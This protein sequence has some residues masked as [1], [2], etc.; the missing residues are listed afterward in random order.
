CFEDVI[1]ACALYRPGPLGSGM[2]DDFIDR[3]H[4]KK[5]VVYDLPELEPILKDTYGVIVYQE[6][7]MQIARSLAGYSLGGADLLRRAMGKKDPA[8]MAKEKDKFLD[9]A[10][11]LGVNLKKAEAIFDLMAKFAEYGFNKS[12]SAAYALVAYQTA[13]LKSHYPVEFMAALL[14][15]DMGNTDKIVKNISDCRDMEIEVLPPDINSSGLSFRVFGNSIRFGLGAVKNVG[16]GAIEAIIDAR[17]KG[18][19]PN[20]FDFCERVDLRRVNRRVVESLVKCGAFDSTGARRSQLMAALDDA[21]NLGQKIQ[22]ERDSAQ[23]SLFG[24]A[25]IVK[26]NGNGQGKLPDLPEWDAKLL[27]GFEKEAIGFF[28]TGHPLGRYVADMKRFATADCAS[29]ADLPDKSDVRICGIVAGL[30]ESITKKGDRMG[31]VTL[32]DLTGSV[33]VIVFPE[34]YAKA[35]EHLKSEEPLVVSG[36][37]D[38][39]EKSTKIKATDVVPLCD[40]TEK[41]TKRVCLTLKTSGLEREALEALKGVIGRHRGECRVCLRFELPERLAVTV[42]LPVSYAVAAREDLSLE[43]EGLLGYNAVSFE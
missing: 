11:G 10:K 27:L 42:N 4:G 6:Q 21:M 19:F 37:V 28:I 17:E 34:I 2:V 33:E 3:K 40:V 7:V 31:F 20:I 41:E 32:E 9:G 43:V 16:E 26:A 25:E 35:V 30:K 13:Y 8:A 23:V 38:I 36:N 15:E 12:H 1:A 14:T 24:T 22:Q 39:G 29:L 5:K 18:P